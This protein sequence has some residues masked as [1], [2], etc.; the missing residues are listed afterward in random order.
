MKNYSAKILLFDDDDD[1]F[2]ERV[3]NGVYS[4][5]VYKHQENY[6]ALNQQQRAEQIKQLQK[7]WSKQLDCF[8]KSTSLN[9][10]QTCFFLLHCCLFKIITKNAVY[11]F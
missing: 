4:I 3:E 10:T 6:S 1:V 11:F 9:K 2:I 7:N 5:V 8:R